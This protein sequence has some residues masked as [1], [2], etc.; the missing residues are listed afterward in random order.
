MKPHFGVP[1]ALAFGCALLGVVSACAGGDQPDDFKGFIDG[2]VL[3]A[4]FLPG[5]CGSAPCYPSQQGFAH[6]EP[7]YFYNVGALTTSTLP[8]L[9]AEAAPVVYGFGSGHCQLVGDYQPMRDAYSS[10]KQFPLFTALPLATRTAGVVVTPFVNVVPIATNGPFSCND[11]KDAQWVGH[12]D[13]APGKYALTAGT[14]GEIRL[15]AVIDPT[16]P[17]APST[18][19][20]ALA[21]QYGWYK[22]LLLTYLDGGPV[23]VNDKGELVAMDGVILDPAGVTTFAKATDPKVV[24]LPFKRGEDGYSP[25]VKL[26]SWRLPAGKVAGD[27]TGICHGTDCGAKDVDIT[28]AAAAAFNTIFVVAQ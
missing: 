1:R 17:L 2:T 13:T 14:T 21:V 15:W 3:D 25:I 20:F 8:T 27:F 11:V 28:Q 24:L 9:K 18:P 12:G 10:E 23:P 26:H 5:K 6:G 16:A 4:K 19:N 22:D 7:L